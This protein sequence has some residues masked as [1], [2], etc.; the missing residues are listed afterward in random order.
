MLVDFEK[1]GIEAIE[2]VRVDDPSTYLRVVAGILPR[3]LTGEDGEALFTGITVNFV[4]PAKP[5]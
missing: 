5:E 2:K 3:E 1:G 4:R